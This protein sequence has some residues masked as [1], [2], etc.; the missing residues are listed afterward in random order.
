MDL[1]L[2]NSLKSTAMKKRGIGLLHMSFQFKEIGKSSWDCQATNT[3]MNVL[4]HQARKNISDVNSGVTSL[5]PKAH[6]RRMF[7]LKIVQE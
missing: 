5:A 7:F 1:Y 4:A 2:E 6:V 3:C